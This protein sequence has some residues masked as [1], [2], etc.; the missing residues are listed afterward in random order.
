LGES[1]SFGLNPDNAG[2]LK[3]MSAMAIAK[4]IVRSDCA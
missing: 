1:T 3:G 2:W 4:Q